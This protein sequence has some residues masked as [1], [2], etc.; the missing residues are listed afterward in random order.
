MLPLLAALIPT[1]SLA[2]RGGGYAEDERLVIRFDALP[3]V[4]A[5]DVLEVRLGLYRE[6]PGR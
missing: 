2:G 3:A 4:A 1:C 6:W 5:R